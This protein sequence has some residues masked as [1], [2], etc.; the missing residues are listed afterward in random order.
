MPFAQ[1]WKRYNAYHE[2]NVL[3][4]HIGFT[5]Y[6]EYLA[7]NLWKSIRKKILAA[8]PLCRF[9]DNIATC[10]HHMSYAE[11]ILLGKE[12]KGLVPL[13]HGHHHYLEFDS[14]G[15]KRDFGSMKR[16]FA[17]LTRSKLRKGLTLH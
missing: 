8:R 1:P 17:F 14:N 13:C 15:N 5:D 11:N 3:L 16:T 10:V 6:G 12:L 2:R 4:S 9:C 7:S